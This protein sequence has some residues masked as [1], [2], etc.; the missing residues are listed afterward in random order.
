MLSEFETTFTS[1]TGTGIGGGSF[2]CNDRIV[3][4][5]LPVFINEFHYQNKDTDKNEGVEISG[6]WGFDLSGYKIYLYN[7]CESSNCAV[8]RGIY[9]GDPWYTI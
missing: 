8:D 1:G 9:G 3:T 2:S 4:N 5:K 7:G 6:P